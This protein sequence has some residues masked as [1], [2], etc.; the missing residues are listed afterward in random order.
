MKPNREPEIRAWR[1]PALRA[2]GEGDDGRPRVIEGRA[3]PYETW[4]D[5]GGWYEECVGKGAFDKSI[6]EAARSLPLL[7]WHDNRS[8]PVGK[9]TGWESR[10]DGLYGVWELADTPEAQRAAALAKDGFLD[11][12][13][14]G[15]VPIRSEW[16]FAEDQDDPAAVDRVRRVEARL[17]E[18]SLT[19]TPAYAGA[20]VTLVRSADREGRN[21]RRDKLTRWQSWRDTLASK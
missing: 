21:A 9:A 16:S 5:V 12:L 7:L 8:W 15:Y 4:D 11:G 13:S 14:V 6:A 17:V 10:D 20:G 19:P 2:V 3:V 1:V 18:V